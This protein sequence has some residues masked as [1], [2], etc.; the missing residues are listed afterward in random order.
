M[1]KEIKEVIEVLLRDNICINV[2]FYA[3]MLLPT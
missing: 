2:D 3:V 1:K